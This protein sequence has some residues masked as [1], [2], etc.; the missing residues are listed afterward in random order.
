MPSDP[1][2]RH[3]PVTLQEAAQAAPSLARLTA[4]VRESSQRLEAIKAHIPPGL[5]AAVAAG[6]LDG[7]S[8]C[9]LVRGSAAAA[10]LRQL[11]PL[12]QAELRRSGCPVD[13][14]RIKVQTDWR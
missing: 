7:G 5:R 11:L 6:P 2:R 13:A 9:L 8:W 3:H 4:L 12:L 14:I 1:T 10:K